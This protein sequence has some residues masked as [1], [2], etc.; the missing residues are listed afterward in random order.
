MIKV[1]FWNIRGLNSLN[2]QQDI[3]WFLHNN[4]IELFGLLETRIRSRNWNKF[5]NNLGSSWSICS[6]NSLHK[7][8]RIWC[9]WNP[10]VI[11]VDVVMMNIQSILANVTIKT[12][13]VKFWVSL[14]YGLNKAKER[15]SL[16][17]EI[18]QH[19]KIAQGPWMIGGDF[20]NVLHTNERIG[21]VVQWHEIRDFQECVNTCGVQ[22]IKAIGS[23]FTWNN[24]HEADTRVFSR[25]DRLLVNDDWLIQFPNA[26]AYFMPE[27]T[28]D[29]CP[30]VV[31]FEEETA[32]KK[33][34][35]RFYNMWTLA[36]SFMEIVKSNWEQEI[37]GTPMFQIVTK[38]KGLKHEL[39][40][41]NRS[42][43]TDIET[44]AS[45]AQAALADLQKKL[46]DDPTNCVISQAERQLAKECVILQQAKNEFLAQKSKVRWVMEGDDNTKYFH[47]TLKQRRANNKVLRI[48]DMDGN[49]HDNPED[50]N[51]AFVAYYTTLLGQAAEVK[52]IHAEVVQT[53]PLITEE[54]MEILT[55]E[56]TG[57]EI[58]EAMFAIQNDKAPGP[59]G[60]TSKFYKEAW[61]IVGDSV[62][63]A[64]K[65]FFRNGRMLKQIN[66][67]TLTLIPKVD[68]PTSVKEFR[69]I[70]C[71]NT[72]YKC[73][74]KILCARLS[75]ILPSI[76]SPNQS[77]FIKGRDIVE[78]ILVCQDLVKL[79]NRKSCSPRVIMK[80]D[81]QKAYDTI[82]WSFLEEMLGALKFPRK[83]IC[84]VMECVSTPKYS[85]ALNG[86]VF[87]FFKGGRGLRQGDPLS[88]LL[89]TICL[90]YLSRL[91][92][93]V[94]RM[95]GFKHHALCKRVELNHLCFADDL[96]MFSY[97]NAQSVKLLLRAFASFSNASG[98]CMNKDKSSIYMN[99]IAEEE[100]M[101]IVSMAKMKKGLL[102][103]RYL[104]VPIAAK[105]LSIA[106]C[107]NLVE[108]M[109]R[110]IRALGARKL[111][112]GG[113]LALIKSVLSH[114]QTYW[115]RIFILPKSVIK[116]LSSIC[117]NFLWYGH[118]HYHHAPPVGWET[119]CR[120]KEYGGLGIF[121]PILW[122]IAAIG[123]Y[124]WWIARKKD[125]L[126]I[127]WIQAVYMKQ[128]HWREYMPTYNASWSWRKICWV[129]E[130]LKNGYQ[131]DWWQHE[132]QHYSVSQGYQ[133]L[134]H[135]QHKVTWQH[136][137]WNRISLPKHTF[138]GWLWAWNR[139]GTRDR[140]QRFGGGDD[141]IC[142]LCGLMP[143][144][145]THLFFECDYSRR[146]VAVA[147]NWLGIQIPFTD[148]IQWWN[149]WRNRS[150]LHKQMVAAV[151]LSLVYYV[152]WARNKCRNDNSVY[153]PTKILQLIQGELSIRFRRLSTIKSSHNVM[154]L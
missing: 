104:G 72:L 33:G 22:D 76:I 103:F 133:W 113:R 2:K 137:I 30:C 101:Q 8:G 78:N 151:V 68:I 54:Q 148:I 5:R 7:G 74:T 139:L 4:K 129:K 38:L 51:K 131:G 116:E 66:A 23:F 44:S 85:I 25:I 19:C 59:D 16:W 93:T 29:H 60:Y 115:A 55:R 49:L 124:V 142:G 35:F 56:V 126:W 122:N 138:I 132:E 95:Q 57:S 21:S 154:L 39:K 149:K 12:T 75:G 91:L 143:E 141:V 102:P 47:S 50:I 114:T 62:I 70:A 125:H 110:R 40:G 73:I 108:K 145:H 15:T 147:N 43:F 127:R 150:L 144:T 94:Q 46:S 53:G 118:E 31:H 45:V 112:Y 111:S 97:G 130:K 146:C 123:K 6:N 121:N 41:L 98:L 84:L 18:K 140:L 24:K 152:W 58:K 26:Y 89:F 87:G 71:C 82:E 77:A 88:P 135:A 90:E 13:K 136:L 65:D 134:L 9:I 83:F 109:V 48:V 52:H 63:V 64:I 27:G 34:P 117:R 128:Q 1:G 96:L 99:G 100:Q 10:L 120:P 119:L 14:V 81:L 36:P 153:H 3:K 107:A 106:D 32:R 69:P 61:P 37:K 79:Y 17:N 20:N 42:Q 67:T 80:I 86:D 105:K 11:E 92:N 28:Y